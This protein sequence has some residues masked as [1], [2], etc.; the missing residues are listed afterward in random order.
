MASILS[1]G[2]KSAPT[3]AQT[4]TSQTTSAPASTNGSQSDVVTRLHAAAARSDA[5]RDGRRFRTLN[6]LDD[7]NR[8]ALGIEVD[9]SLPAGRVIRLLQRL[10]DA[11]GKP[12]KLRC[13]NGPRG[14]RPSLSVQF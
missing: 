14:G 13:N 3:Q 4:A 1:D 6:V 9:Y 2:A 11:Y 5:L 10:V 8:E 7:Y 12:A